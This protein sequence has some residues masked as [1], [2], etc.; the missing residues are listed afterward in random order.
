[1]W[2][3]EEGVFIFKKCNEN[4]LKRR[5]ETGMERHGVRYLHPE[6]LSRLSVVLIFLSYSKRMLC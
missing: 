2:L 6:T 1:M 5:N 4:G 3:Y